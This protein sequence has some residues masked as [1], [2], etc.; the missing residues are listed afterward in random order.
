MVMHNKYFHLNQMHFTLKASL[1]GSYS[2]KTKLQTGKLHCYSMTII[3]L[4]GSH[5]E[6]P[7]IDYRCLMPELD[8]EGGQSACSGSKGQTQ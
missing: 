6:I 3:I 1:S 5:S 2:A 8:R 4:P 7:N